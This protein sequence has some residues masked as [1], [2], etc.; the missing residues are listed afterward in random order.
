[1][2]RVF[3]VADVRLFREGV[4]SFLE[5]QPGIA[6]VGAAEAGV[7]VP[8]LAAADPEIVLVDIPDREKL[9]TVRWLTAQAP[10][11]KV[12]V[13]GVTEMEDELIACAQAGIAGYVLRDGSLEDLLTTIEAAARDEFACS[14]AVAAMLLRCVGRHGPAGG[15]ADA[16]RRLDALTSR[17]AEIVTLIGQGLSNKQ[18]AAR[19]HLA[20]STVKNHIH[21][22]MQ[23]LDTSRRTEIAILAQ[24][25]GLAPPRAGS[26]E[27]RQAATPVQR[28]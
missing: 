10:G 5:T 19:L 20:L 11:I 4:A 24:A 9:L 2:I 17:E 25:A 15:D 27:I 21:S 6:V 26:R 23:K 13:V 28:E 18:I 8:L 1:V 14:P 22:V 3:V 16:G 12:V 7:A